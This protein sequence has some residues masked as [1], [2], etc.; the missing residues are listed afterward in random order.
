MLRIHPH[1]LTL[2][3]AQLEPRLWIKDLSPKGQIKMPCL[4][5]QNVNTSHEHHIF[6]ASSP[7]LSPHTQH[8]LTLATRPCQS[9]VR[10]K[11]TTG[12][13]ATQKGRKGQQVHIIGA[14]LLPSC[15]E[16]RPA[17]TAVCLGIWPSP[18]SCSPGLNCWEW[19]PGMQLCCRVPEGHVLLSAAPRRVIER[20]SQSN[21][22]TLA[23][24]VDGRVYNI[25]VKHQSMYSPK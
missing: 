4:D 6:G 9:Y 17:G 25:D 12:W 14:H 21:S 15:P 3:G 1:E 19:D 23:H 7:L 20:D 22:G 13:P 16:P 10:D 18:R 5:E 11:R 24:T 8:A 2:P